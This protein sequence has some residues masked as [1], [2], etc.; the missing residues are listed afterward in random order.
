MAYVA[1]AQ[2]IRTERNM[3]KQTLDV[4][5][6]AVIVG[7][8]FI[9]G[10]RSEATQISYKGLTEILVA[11]S[12]WKGTWV[13]H[14]MDLRG[15]ARKQV[16]TIEMEFFT[17]YGTILRGAIKKARGLAYG[18]IDG[19]LRDIRV[20]EAGEVAFISSGG[21]DFDLKLEDGRLVGEAVTQRNARGAVE[22]MP[23]RR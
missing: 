14:W 12:P 15:L 23:T 4:A 19:P 1:N 17:Q 13:H 10:T 21:W 11:R 8:V 16:V 5:A 22:L 7:S 6:L 20:T 9:A 3:K 2:E 18:T